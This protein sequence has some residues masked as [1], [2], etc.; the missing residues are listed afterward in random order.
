MNLTKCPKCHNV[1]TPDDKF[2]PGCGANL[3]EFLSTQSSV[4]CS[5]CG[6]RNPQSASFCEK[7]GNTLTEP[8]VVS[9]KDPKE[10]EGPQKIV[11]KGSYSGKMNTGKS[12]L[13]KRLIIAAVIIV[14]LCAVA[15]I[16]WFQVDDN[17]E[18]KLKE[19]LRIPGAVVIIG[20]AVYVAIFGKSKKGRRG[21]GNYDDDDWDDDDDG[22][23]GD[24]GGDDD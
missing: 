17:A 2:C 22:D 15:I 19:A 5:R 23:W 24:D 1:V 21:G 10:K 16:I 4:F 14:L 20:F 7:C 11:S 8:P 18:E 12:K 13:L 6:H 3:E 9:N